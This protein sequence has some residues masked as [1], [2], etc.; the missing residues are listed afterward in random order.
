MENPFADFTALERRNVVIYMLGIMLY[1]FGLEAFTGSITLLAADRFKETN[2]FERL[3]ILQGLNLAFQCVGSIAIAP[4]IKRFPTR[5]VLACSVAI[6]GLLSSII[7]IIDVSTG[8]KIPLDKKPRFGQWDPVLLFPIYCIIGICHGMVELIRR[9]IPRDVVG[10][11]V[12]K[13]KRMDAIVHIANE[14]TGTA[15][16]FFASY[17][18]LNLGSAIA[19]AITPF[20]FLAAAFAWKMVSLLDSDRENR[21]QLESVEQGS[22]AK[23][24]LHG[25]GHFGTSMYLGAQIIFSSR[26]YI[27]LLPGYSLSLFTHRYLEGQLSPAFAKRVLNQGAYSQ[28]MNGGSN[29]G[30]FLGAVFV[31]FLAK[32]IKTPLPWLRLDAL[33]LLIIW[34]LPYSYPKPE[35]ALSYAWIMAGIF[36]PISLGWSAGDVSLAAYIQSTL[37]KIERPDDK[38]SSLGAVMAFLYVF[39]IV[40]YAVLSSLL[41]KVMDKAFAKGDIRPAFVYVGGV[42]FTV[43]SVIIIAATFI[44]KGSFALNPEIFNDDDDEKYGQDAEIESELKGEKFELKA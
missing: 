30:E 11:D 43:I 31:L 8:G 26:R 12:V 37:T 42:M 9:V 22:L 21:R 2:T 33:A 15:G 25:F 18:V 28:I 39:N 35:E 32:K 5:S 4:L 6:F 19:P 41:G 20:F 1:K 40:V 14:A 34:V 27:W 16:A 13:L 10:G 44:P 23:Q 38:V 3:A 24:I 7:I 17:L 29:F 36:M